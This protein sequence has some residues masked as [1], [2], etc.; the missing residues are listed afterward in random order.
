MTFE[1]LQILE[2]AKSRVAETARLVRGQQRASSYAGV[3]AARRTLFG[4][5]P[6]TSITRAAPSSAIT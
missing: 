1:D 6:S 5:P 2:L 3:G 4:R